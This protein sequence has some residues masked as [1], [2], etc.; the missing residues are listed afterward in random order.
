MSRKVEQMDNVNVIRD[1]I[2]TLGQKL[3]YVVDIDD[4]GRVIDIM[5]NGN[6]A[7]AAAEIQADKTGHRIV[8]GYCFVA[9]NRLNDEVPMPDSFDPSSID[10][11]Y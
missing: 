4:G 7:Q 10:R 8:L 6:M 3:W 1:D 2:G 9:D 5:A 11:L